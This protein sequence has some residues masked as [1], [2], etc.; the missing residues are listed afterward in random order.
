MC[1]NIPAQD[2]FGGIL[3]T[4]ESYRVERPHLRELHMSSCQLDLFMDKSMIIHLISLLNSSVFRFK[5]IAKLKGIPE[6]D[7]RRDLFRKKACM[8]IKHIK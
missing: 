1:T 2:F 8:Q 6:D 3:L 4:N 5:K 7:V